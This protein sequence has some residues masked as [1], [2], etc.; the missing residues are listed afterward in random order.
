MECK[1]GL[2]VVR[3]IDP[4]LEGAHANQVARFN[5]NFRASCEAGAVEHGAGPTVKIA[6]PHVPFAG[7]LVGAPNQRRMS[8]ADR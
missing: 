5:P 7:A 6:Q 1:G 3:A 4:E 8:A 2:S